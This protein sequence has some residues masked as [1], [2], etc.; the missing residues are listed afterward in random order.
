MVDLASVNSAPAVRRPAVELRFGDADAEAWAEALVSVT[1][2]AGIGPGVDAVEVI[3]AAGNGGP[4]AAVGDAGTVALGYDDASAEQV[5]AGEVESVG[6]SIHGTIRITAVNG[7]AA[8]ARLRLN[9][10][11]EQQAAGDVISDL[12]GEA[13]VA[14]ATIEAG[15]DLPFYVVDDRRTAWEHVAALARRS[16]CW[17][18]FIP[19]GELE[20]VAVETGPAVQ[21]FTYGEDILGIEMAEATPLV[22]GVR[23]VGEGAAGSEGDEAWCWLVKDPSGVSAEAGDEPRREV[24]DPALRSADAATTA[25]EGHLASA[26]LLEVT[27]RLL[28]PG[29]PAVVPGATIEIADAPEESLNGSFLVRHVRHRYAKGAGFITLIAFSKAAGGAGGGLP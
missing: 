22:S 19:D 13:G 16:G 2:E 8:L 27:G 15:V 10:S 6:R 11:Y 25:A 18:Y 14:T 12:A 1:V 23:A 24:P 26:G 17:S 7:G 21:T 28:V 3:A 29:S 4:A 9:R 20:V 5:F